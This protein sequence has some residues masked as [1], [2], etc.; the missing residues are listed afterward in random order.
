MKVFKELA[1]ELASQPLTSI[2]FR[3]K[4]T[5]IRLEREEGKKEHGVFWEEILISDS[6]TFGQCYEPIPS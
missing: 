5:C 4:I 2:K 6:K 1:Q 3:I